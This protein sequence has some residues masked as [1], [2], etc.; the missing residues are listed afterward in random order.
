ME[1]LSA[2]SSDGFVTMTSLR[3]LRNTSGGKVKLVA[4]LASHR[5]KVF[6]FRENCLKTLGEMLTVALWEKEAY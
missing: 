6:S 3:I 2:P 5:K 1:A 4:T